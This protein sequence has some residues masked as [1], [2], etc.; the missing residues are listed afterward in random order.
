VIGTDAQLSYGLLVDSEPPVGEAFTPE[1]AV[2]TIPPPLIRWQARWMQ[3]CVYIMMYSCSTVTKICIEALVCTD[4]DGVKLVAASKNVQCGSSDHTKMTVCAV[5]FFL[6]FSVGGPTIIAA[7]MFDWASTSHLLSGIRV[8]FLQASYKRKSTW[9][10]NFELVLLVRRLVL[11]AVSILVNSVPSSSKQLATL[12][13]VNVVLFECGMIHARL[14][15]FK[16]SVHNHME[17]AALT[18]NFALFNLALI[19]NTTWLPLVIDIVRL[20]VFLAFVGYGVYENS[21]NICRAV[22]SG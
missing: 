13:C 3:C 7:K 20:A 9:H 21:G 15:P 5:I 6:V 19:P 16:N 1:D 22:R 18:T 14:L 12:L 2:L 10:V 17:T 11:V 4:Y 8:A